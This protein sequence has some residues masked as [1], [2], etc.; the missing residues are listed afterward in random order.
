MPV[1]VGKKPELELDYVLHRLRIGKE[2]FEKNKRISGS[3]LK[4][5]EEAGSLVKPVLF[6]K[7]LSITEAAEKSITLEGG[8]RIESDFV[9]QKLADAKSVLVGIITIGKDLEERVKNIDD[10]EGLTYKYILD[11]LAI[12]HIDSAGKDFFKSLEPVLKEKG[13][14]MGTAMGPGET[15]GWAVAE[16]HKLFDALSDEVEGVSITKD[17]ILIPAKSGSF[18][19]GLFDRPVKSG[20]NCD[21]CSARERCTFRNTD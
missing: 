14:Y 9:A 13:L 4:A 6:Y 2:Q 8:L 18:A 12:I 15:H 1:I 16:Q 5:M 3:V 21:Y 20:S 10:S 11:A 17:N 19:A 7:Q